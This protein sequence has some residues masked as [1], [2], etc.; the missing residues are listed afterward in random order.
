[1]LTAIHRYR[2]YLNPKT[3][4]SNVTQIPIQPETGTNRDTDTHITQVRQN[5]KKVLRCTILSSFA[6]P[7][8]RSN[9]ALEDTVPTTLHRGTRPGT[10]EISRSCWACLVR[11][12]RINHFAACDSA[13]SCAGIPRPL[14]ERRVSLITEVASSCRLPGAICS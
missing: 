2:P 12:F 10:R 3:H 8:N 14:V 13:S 1:M 4:I 9:L 5:E 6:S 11:R 7:Q